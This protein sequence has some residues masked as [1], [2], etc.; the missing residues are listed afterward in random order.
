MNLY[1]LMTDVRAGSSSERVASGTRGLVTL[2]VRANSEGEAVAHAAAILAK[3]A[4]SAIGPLNVYLEESTGDSTA[5]MGE[6]ES[7]AERAADSTAT[8]Y[9][10]IKQS[11]LRDADGLFEAWLPEGDEGLAGDAKTT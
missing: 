5:V 1:R 2:W 8:G 10:A 7:T 11:A 9:D 6:V 4:Y 3:R